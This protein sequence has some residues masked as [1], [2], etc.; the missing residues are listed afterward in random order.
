MIVPENVPTP[1][2]LARAGT[3]LATPVD[4]ETLMNTLDTTAPLT[5]TL[6]NS[7][8]LETPETLPV[9]GLGAGVTPGLTVVNVS[10]F[11]ERLKLGPPPPP[12]DEPPPPHPA[13]DNRSNHGMALRSRPH[14]Q[15]PASVVQA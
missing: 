11:V 14:K 6:M 1:N 8:P 13:G 12:P 5:T 15:G 4:P 2:V 3:T 7:V 9:T 10:V